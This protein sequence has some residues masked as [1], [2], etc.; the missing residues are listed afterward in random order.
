MKF[1]Y[2]DRVKVS[3]GF[4]KGITGYIIDKIEV[5]FLISSYKFLV[6]LDKCYEDLGR[7]STRW[8]HEKDLQLT[9]KQI[10]QRKGE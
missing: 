8:I 1:Q 6:Q 3:S 9:V 7:R 10:N 4:Y 2:Y 5:G